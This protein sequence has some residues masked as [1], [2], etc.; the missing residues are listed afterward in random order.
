MF[1]I[2]MSLQDFG[3]NT[4]VRKRMPWLWISLSALYSNKV[5]FLGAIINNGSLSFYSYGN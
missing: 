1:E 3:F 4:K 5:Y 2:S